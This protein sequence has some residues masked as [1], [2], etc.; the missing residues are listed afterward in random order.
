MGH[1]TVAD[2]AALVLPPGARPTPAQE[3]AFTAAIDSTAKKVEDGAGYF[4][5]MAARN[6]NAADAAAALASSSK[7][8]AQAK[9]KK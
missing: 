3:E 5:L 9:A 6:E 1:C 2:V 8:Q 7:P 4:E